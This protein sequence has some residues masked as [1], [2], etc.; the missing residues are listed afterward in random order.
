M[1][2][3]P[4]PEAFLSQGMHTIQMHD[5]GLWDEVYRTTPEEGR[6]LPEYLTMRKNI[7]RVRLNFPD[8]KN[9]PKREPPFSVD[10]HVQIPPSSKCRRLGSIDARQVDEQ[11]APPPRVSCKP[12]RLGGVSE[13][14]EVLDPSK[15]PAMRY[16]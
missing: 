1:Y 4:P 12:E 11:P 9:P 6:Y 14:V 5:P 3:L 8:P 10:V 15:Y 13:R 7:Y 16:R 2:P